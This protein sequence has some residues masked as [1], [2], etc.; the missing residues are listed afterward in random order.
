M[1]Y[2][3]D[4]V[5]SRR[6]TGSLKWDVKDNELP[7]WVADMDFPVA[8]PI[9]DAI[10]ERASHPIYGYQ[11]YP[12]EWKAAYRDF[13]LS[14]FGVDIKTEWLSYATGIVPIVSSAVRAFSKPGEYVLVNN[15]VYNIFH[16]SIENNGRKILSSDLV[17]DGKGYHIDFTDLE[18]KLSRPDVHLYILCNPQNPTGQIHSAQDLKRIAELAEKNDVVIISDEIHGPLTD[19][20]KTYVPLLK[21]APNASSWIVAASPTKAFNIAG[22][23]C[24]AFYTPNEEL[25]KRLDTQLNIDECNE[26]N[27]FSFPAMI[28]AYE[29]SRDWLL[30]CRETI[31]RN[32][33]IVKDYLKENAPE[34][35]LIDGEATYLLWIS[36]ESLGGDGTAFG[37]FLREKTGL[38][39]NPGEHY[40][41][42]GK[43]FFRLNIACPKA[44]L[45]DGLERLEKG[46][47]LYKE[48]ILRAQTK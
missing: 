20:G 27:V 47:I 1:K 30:G 43:S 34:L 37:A 38:F 44:T 41:G 31:T 46:T 24:A 6:N 25:R 42:N 17:Y 19:I 29:K 14:L 35:K 13:Y 40:L 39:V 18:E 8:T 12:A 22:I 5:V 26:A 21:A 3:F 2:D 33:K 15:P 45:L 7:M 48:E 32:R 9:K 11:T 28:A 23:Q 36:V 10:L 16:H 4:K